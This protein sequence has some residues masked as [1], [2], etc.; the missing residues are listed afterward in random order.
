M[1]GGERRE[2]LDQRLQ[3]SG[4]GAG[5]VQGLDHGGEGLGRLAIPS[6][7]GEIPERGAGAMLHQ[8]RRSLT[9]EG[10]HC[11]QSTE[12]LEVVKTAQL[13]G[14]AGMQEF[15]DRGIA[16]RLANLP[17]DAGCGLGQPLWIGEMK[18]DKGL[19]QPHRHRLARQAAIR[20]ATAISA[21]PTKPSASG[22]CWKTSQPRSVA[23]AMC[24]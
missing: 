8:E 1:S 2:T 6:R 14:L 20:P 24:M 13:L 23:K 4:I 22:S 12:P 11:P 15:Q 7:A 10:L 9:S 19:V 21:M 18:P 16:I 3:V 17:D 5:G